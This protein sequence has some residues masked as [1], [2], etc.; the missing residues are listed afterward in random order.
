MA[1]AYK[2]LSHAY[3]QLQKAHAKWTPELSA[4]LRE[5]KAED[6]RTKSDMRGLINH[7]CY[8]RSTTAKLNS[9]VQ[10][11]CAD[12]SRVGRGESFSV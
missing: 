10:N 9:D 1:D 5:E 2:H 8:M 6:V 7:V 12:L 4:Y 3:F 11:L